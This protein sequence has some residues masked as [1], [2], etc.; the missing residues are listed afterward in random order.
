MS[1]ILDWSFMS[2]VLSDYTFQIVA[3]GTVVLGIAT[4]VVGS[5]ATLRRESLMGDAL[6]HAAL[7]GIG[8]AF[9]LIQVKITPLLLLGALVTGLIAIFLIQLFTNKLPVKLDGSMALILSSFFGLGLVFLTAI[10]GQENAN[11]AGLSS[12]VFGQ[13]SAMLRSDVRMIILVSA[14]ILLVIALCWY[15]FKLITFDQQY[16]QSIYPNIKWYN[17]TMALLIVA[18]IMIGLESV[19]VIL[20]SALLVGPSIAARQ[21]TDRLLPLVILA[22]V[23][24]AVSSFIG[25][26][27]SSTAGRIP[28]GPA[29]VVVLSLILFASLF[30]APKNGL[31]SQTLR[32]RKQQRKIKREVADR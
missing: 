27:I 7:P 29:I 18:A 6:S 14:I 11:Q 13:A 26:Y 9:I 3:L 16:A 21:W 31:I 15:P 32:R 1:G 4:G 23:F 19:G 22:G 24:G 17:F 10:Q 30:I 20:M 28:T 12:F 5:F 25:T 2:Q 8:L